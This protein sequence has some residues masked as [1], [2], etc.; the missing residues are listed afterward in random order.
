MWVQLRVQQNAPALA[1]RV[2]HMHNA[3][4]RHQGSTFICPLEDRALQ[5]EDITSSGLHQLRGCSGG[6]HAYGA[7]KH[8]WFLVRRCAYGRRDLA[9][10]FGPD[11][12]GQVT[13]FVLLVRA[14]V[15]EQ[16][17]DP[18]VGRH[19]LAEFARVHLWHFRPIVP[20]PG[21]YGVPSDRVFLSSGQCRPVDDED[22]RN[23]Q[24]RDCYHQLQGSARW[25]VLHKLS[26]RYLLVPDVKRRTRHNKRV[27]PRRSQSLIPKPHR[28]ALSWRTGYR[29]ALKPAN[30]ETH[31]E[32][33]TVDRQAR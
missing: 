18:T 22:L 26:A 24:K 6:T 9:G 28:S 11:G 7:V 23:Q 32:C 27:C 3:T 15:D 31:V 2:H 17:G 33:S 4:I 12:S 10:R 21:K 8:D 1:V 30:D 19:P 25:I 29:G 13:D 20:Y 14:H 5:I 16:R